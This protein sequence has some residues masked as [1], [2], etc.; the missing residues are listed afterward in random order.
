MRARSLS[1]IDWPSVP[2]GE[3]LHASVAADGR[4]ASPRVPAVHLRTAVGSHGFDDCRRPHRPAGVVVV[5]RIVGVADP[6]AELEV[7]DDGRHPVAGPAGLTQP[8]LAAAEV[9]S[10]E[11]EAQRCEP[12]GLVGVHRRTARLIVRV[13]RMGGVGRTDLG[14]GGGA[15]C[16][17]TDY[18]KTEDAEG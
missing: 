7:P 14:V 15:S 13:V 2:D 18:Q 10:G 16:A 4:S 6:V 9:R 5:G 8:P 17:A 3:G 11:V 1:L 12:T